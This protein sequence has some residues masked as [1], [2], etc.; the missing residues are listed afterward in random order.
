MPS[1]DALPRQVKRKYITGEA[2]SVRES[3]YF[4]YDT[5][6][7]YNDQL[8]IVCGG[9]EKCSPI[10]NINRNNYPY[11]FVKYTI[12]G[13]GYLERKGEQFVL[14]PGVLT[15][16]GPAEAHHYRSDPENPLEHIFITFLGTES[17]PLLQKSNLAAGNILEV[18]NPEETMNL[19]Q[20]ILQTGL[21]RPAHSQEICCNYLRIMLLQQASHQALAK[22][23]TTPSLATYR[24]CLQFIH[25]HF[26]QIQSPRDAAEACH[27]DVRYMS[28]LFKRYCHIPPSQYIMRLKLN[29]AA[30]LLL[31]T[32]LPVKNVGLEVGF[33]DPYHFSNCFKKFHGRS[34]RNYRRAHIEQK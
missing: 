13:R 12:T 33:D 6:P 15:G 18:A 7:N 29:K 4:Y 27:V 24:T 14:H 9:Y 11:Y 2:D 19:F 20:H 5:A 21:E 25:S 3:Q 34:P 31:H 8:A 23:L 17:A 26:S 32:E 16:F 28:T 22:S 10:Y 1:S 30:N